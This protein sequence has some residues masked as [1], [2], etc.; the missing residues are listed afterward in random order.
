MTKPQPKPADKNLT[1]EKLL[2]E[3]FEK[4]GDFSR[5]TMLELI[6]LQKLLREP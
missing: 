2:R 1:W 4:K 6:E 3:F 5:T